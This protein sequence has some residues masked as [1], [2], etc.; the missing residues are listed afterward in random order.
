MHLKLCPN[1]LLINKLRY[2]HNIFLDLDNAMQSSQP[3]CVTDT[4]ASK[5]S[6]SGLIIFHYTKWFLLIPS[7]LFPHEDHNTLTNR[8]LV[9]L[10][11]RTPPAFLSFALIRND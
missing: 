2:K 5:P 9:N 10:E 8:P 3:V 11:N 6:V 1:R 4:F 7:A